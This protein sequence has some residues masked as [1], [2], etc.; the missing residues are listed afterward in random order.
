MGL[1]REAERTCHGAFLGTRDDCG[2]DRFAFPFDPADRWGC[3][4]AEILRRRSPEDDPAILC[5]DEGDLVM[6]DTSSR[7]SIHPDVQRVWPCAN[8]RT[9]DA[10]RRRPRRIIV[11]PPAGV[12][13]VPYRAGPVD[14]DCGWPDV[15]TGGLAVVTPM[16]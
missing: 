3:R 1:C 9:P 15:P 13:P 7:I 11:A 12:V 14:H 8:R 10:G 6:V 16:P 2:Q 5:L 4:L